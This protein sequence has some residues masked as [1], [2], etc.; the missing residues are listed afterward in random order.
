MITKACSILG[1]EA[2]LSVI[3]PFMMRLAGL[4]IP[5]ARASVEMMYEFT[6][7]FIVDSDQFQKAFK[8]QATL[9]DDA[10]ERT[11]SWYKDSYRKV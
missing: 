5:E 11:I 7:P 2:K 10:L 8:I 3:S 1:I 9:I 6:E 4:L